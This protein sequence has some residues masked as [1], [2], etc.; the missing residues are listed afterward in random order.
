MRVLLLFLL[1]CFL[2]C[3]FLF[4]RSSLLY[5]CLPACLC[6]RVCSRVRALV[7]VLG[8]GGMCVCVCSSL[9]I[10]LLRPDIT[11]VVDW[12]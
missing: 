7:C 3:V 12:A 8:G 1:V 11:T 9:F 2:F 10:S 6:A 4:A 5:A